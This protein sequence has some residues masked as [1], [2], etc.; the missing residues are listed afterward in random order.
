MTPEGETD[1]DDD[2]GIQPPLPAPTAFSP[3]YR[4]PQLESGIAEDVTPQQIREAIQKA[5]EASAAQLKEFGI[6]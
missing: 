2:D 3:V 5:C 1:E 6:I 4:I